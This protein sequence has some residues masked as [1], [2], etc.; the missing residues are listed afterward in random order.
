MVE[1]FTLRCVESRGLAAGQRS[2]VEHESSG[3]LGVSWIDERRDDDRPKEMR[4]EALPAAPAHAHVG[5]VVR[6]C[7][8]WESPS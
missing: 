1:G 2:M 6:V 3:R 4:T 5:T 7:C 8:K